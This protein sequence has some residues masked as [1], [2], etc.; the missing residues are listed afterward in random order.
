MMK[1]PTYKAGFEAL[2]KVA[3]ERNVA[4]QTIKGICARPWGERNQS[5][6]TW[7]EPLEDQHEIDLAVHYVLSN[8]QVFLNT[9]G[10]IHVMPRVLD[11][12]SR[13]D[14]A[15]ASQQAIGEQIDTLA[16]TPLFT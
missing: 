7:Y 1:N 5:R 10:D 6:A 8:P 4:V 16:L 9:V 11:A 3:A 12:A 14:P 2:L 15:T 13:F